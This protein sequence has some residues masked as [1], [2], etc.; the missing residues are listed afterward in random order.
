MKL[1]LFALVMWFCTIGLVLIQGRIWWTA[2]RTGRW[3][4]GGGRAYYFPSKYYTFSVYD[5]T[6][7]PC[8]YRLAVTLFPIMWFSLLLCCV[9]LTIVFVHNALTSA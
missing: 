3:L 6:S 2:V 1:F 5:R 7:N 8:M 4:L 9:L